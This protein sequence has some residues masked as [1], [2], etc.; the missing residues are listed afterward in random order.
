MGQR[1]HSCPFLAPL[2][3]HQD[4]YVA[5]GAHAHPLHPW[6][7]TSLF[8]LRVRNPFDNPRE[9]HTSH[10]RHPNGLRPF[11][12]VG[13]V[14]RCGRGGGWTMLR[15]FIHAAQ[16]LT[17]SH[18]DLCLFL[19]RFGVNLQSPCVLRIFS[20]CFLLWG[21]GKDT[22]H[23]NSLSTHTS[24]HVLPRTSKISHHTCL[25]IHSRYFSLR[26]CCYACPIFAFTKQR[27]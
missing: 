6:F 8:G 26:L 17:L 1:D 25:N 27:S 23:H 4:V 19:A 18:R 2:H 24:H 5:F 13:G 20:P 16:S 12:R 7:R 9:R 21:G 3:P 10:P 15:S 22:T 14:V 11:P